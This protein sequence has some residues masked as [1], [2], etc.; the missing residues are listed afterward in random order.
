MSYKQKMQ[1]LWKQYEDEHGAEPLSIGE[2][3]E[4]AKRKGLWHPKPLDVAKIF[5]REMADALREET[6]VDAS[7][8]KY[9]AKLCVRE[10]SGG[11]QMSLWGDI[12][13]SS[14]DFVEK[15]VQQRRKG[16]VDDGYQLKMDVDHFNE[17]RSP[18]Q[19]L[20]LVLDI[21]DDVAERE[22]LERDDDEDKGAG[23]GGAA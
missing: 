23:G 10:S 22:A 7:G 19:P 14:R 8:R 15:S 2:C 11:V 12:D 6:R 18:E 16:L 13:K 3:F 20:Q 9:R 1:A 5:N 17:F 4:W 21:T